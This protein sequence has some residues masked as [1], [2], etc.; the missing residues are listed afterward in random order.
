MDE[1]FLLSHWFCAHEDF[2]HSSTE[3]D[4]LWHSDEPA[5]LSLP[6]P[7]VHHRSGH[8]PRHGLQNHRSPHRTEHQTLSIGEKWDITAPLS[9]GK[10]NLVD[11]AGSERVW[12]SG[13][14][15]ERLKE[16]Q[17]INRSLLALGDVIQAHRARQ[18]HI[19]FRN[20]RLT[21]LL[22]DSLGKGSKT[23]MV[24]QVRFLL[25][26]FL[27][28][29]HQC[30]D[31]GVFVCK[32]FCSGEQRGRNAV[33]SKVCPEGVQGGTRSCSQ[34]DR[35]RR[36][37]VRLNPPESARSSSGTR[38]ILKALQQSWSRAKCAAVAETPPSSR[39][40]V[41]IILNLHAG[42]KRCEAS[43]FFQP[44]RTILSDHFSQYINTS[45]HAEL[46]ILL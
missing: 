32:G 14:E 15:G 7:A 6:R 8:R 42:V 26:P 43:F 34:E 21:Y 24:V 23:V 10:L 33:L 4:H 35:I 25:Q 40:S 20:S 1:D 11:L 19:P 16:A 3:Q 9:A 41:A 46:L 37:A 12:K 39:T 29:G 13:A 45:V 30:V 22:Q 18:T 44:N 2:S 17:N 38:I 5:Q 36:G 31:P 28:S 27:N